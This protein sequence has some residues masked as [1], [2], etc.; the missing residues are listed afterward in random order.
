[1]LLENVSTGRL[2]VMSRYMGTAASGTAFQCQRSVKLNRDS[3]ESCGIKTKTQKN[4]EEP[5]GGFRLN[6]RV[7]LDGV[8]YEV[9][10]FNADGWLSAWDAIVQR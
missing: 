8:L 10:G 7:R 1:V 9:V 4:F 6:T 2:L 5:V 3:W